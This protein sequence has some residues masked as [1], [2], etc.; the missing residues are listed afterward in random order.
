MIRNA[1][2][3]WIESIDRWLTPS[4]MMVSQVFPVRKAFS[5]GLRACSFVTDGTDDVMMCGPHVPSKRSHASASAA[6]FGLLVDSGGTK[7][8]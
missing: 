5:H 3:I 4:E 7:V 8:S 1:G 2:I 6:A